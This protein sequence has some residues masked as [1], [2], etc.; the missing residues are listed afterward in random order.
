MTST[1][2]R[3]AP[4][5]MTGPNQIAED[6]SHTPQYRLHSP[7][8]DDDGNDDDYDDHDNNNNDNN[9][10]AEDILSLLGSS[11]GRSNSSSSN[12]ERLRSL[13]D[14]LTD[15]LIAVAWVVAAMITAYWTNFL[16]VIL[17]SPHAH[18]GLLQ[19]VALCWGINT[20]LC[21][22]LTV[23]LPYVKGLSDSSAWSVY[24]PRVIP[25]STVLFVVAT[26]LLI[27]ATWPVWG[28]LT[29][30]ILGIEA[31]GLLFSLNFIPWPF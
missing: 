15:K 19:I 23:Y 1:Y 16:G 7:E 21:L 18:R 12:N 5:E 30:L 31:M 27:R 13:S 25:V 10:E 4:T 29:P 20:V 6:P 17:H 9:N 2:R 26:L 14:R 8:L 11:S 22:Y 28:C 3:V 24:C